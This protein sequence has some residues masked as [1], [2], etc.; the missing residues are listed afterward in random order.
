MTGSLSLSSWFPGGD[1]KTLLQNGG[2]LLRV[3][4]GLGETGEGG[5]SR[6]VGKWGAGAKGLAPQSRI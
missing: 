4:N 2:K 3:G 1:T 6:E 5:Q